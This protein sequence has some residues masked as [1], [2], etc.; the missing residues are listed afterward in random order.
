MILASE[1]R[2][3]LFHRLVQIFSVFVNISYG[4]TKNILRGG[5]SNASQMTFFMSPI[6]DF[7]FHI[8]DFDLSEGDYS[9]AL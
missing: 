5:I 1:S 9:N 2:C 6:L 7:R 4:L 8:F 3:I